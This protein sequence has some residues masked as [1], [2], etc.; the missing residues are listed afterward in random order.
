MKSKGKEKEPP[1][2]IQEMNIP[3]GEDRTRQ[4]PPESKKS[5][6]CSGKTVDQTLLLWEHCEQG[7]EPR[8]RKMEGQDWPDHRALGHSKN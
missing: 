5:L 7:E 1:L 8:Q 4:C 3:S 2:D 6:K